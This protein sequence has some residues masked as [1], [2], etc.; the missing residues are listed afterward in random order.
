M[1][2]H[3]Y[4]YSVGTDVVAAGV[5]GGTALVSG[6]TGA[7]AGAVSLATGAVATGAVTAGAAVGTEGAGAAVGAVSMSRVIVVWE[8]GASD[9]PTKAKAP[10]TRISNVRPRIAK[11]FICK[12]PDRN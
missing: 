3:F 4:N 6:E 5:C 12:Y 7:A 1:L 9:R 8:T 2:G 10:M 11:I